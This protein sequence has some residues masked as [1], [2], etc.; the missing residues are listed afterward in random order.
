MVQKSSTSS[1]ENK[2]KS[3]E[4]TECIRGLIGPI[5]TGIIIGLAVTIVQIYVNPRAAKGVKIQES[6]TEKRFEACDKAIE[7]MR[8]SLDSATI[9]GKSVPEWYTPTEKAP[10]QTELNSAYL[11][12]LV[13]LK[14]TTV[15][16]EFRAAT[17]PKKIGPNDILKFIS[18]VRKELGIDDKDITNFILRLNRPVNVDELRDT[19]TK[20]HKENE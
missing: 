9:T 12:L 11:Q 2:T 17:A 16:E 8:R 6:I 3:Q 13:Y 1:S 19:E 10:T 7:L 4:S 20:E 14:N 18:T 15:A 5:V